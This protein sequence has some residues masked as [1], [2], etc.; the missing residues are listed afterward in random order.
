[1]I[2]PDVTA[3]IKAKHPTAVLY[4]HDGRYTHGFAVELNGE[5][6]GWHMQN[7]P[8]G[9][10]RVTEAALAWLDDIAEPTHASTSGAH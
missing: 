5:R 7:T 10:A 6:T 4:E 9:W 3:T 2:P 8:Q 1:M